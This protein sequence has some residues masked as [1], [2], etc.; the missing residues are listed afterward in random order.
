[1]SYGGKYLATLCQGDDFTLAVPVLDEQ[2]DPTTLASGESL[3]VALYGING[4]VLF[5]ATEED[6]TYDTNTHR[7]LCE[8]THEYSVNMIGAVPAE[9]T[10]VDADGVAHDK[11]KGVL[12]FEPKQNNELLDEQDD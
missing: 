12:Y 5:H 1:M 10:L 3:L 9:A 2:G 6:M 8:V 7:Y 4:T 11:K